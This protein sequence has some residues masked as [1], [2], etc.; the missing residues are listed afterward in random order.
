MRLVKILTPLLAF[1]LLASGCSTITNLT[2]SRQDRN[3]SGLYPVEAQWDTREQAIRPET[4]HPSVMM[5]L[6]SYP[7]RPTALMNNRWETLLPIPPDKSVARYRFKFDYEESGIPARR[8]ESKLSP[9][10]T[11]QI[12]EPGSAKS[13]LPPASKADQEKAAEAIHKIK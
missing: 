4:L 2:A 12:V 9:E 13:T 8:K 1:L 11:L 3:S 5:G 7:M 10:Y 6:E